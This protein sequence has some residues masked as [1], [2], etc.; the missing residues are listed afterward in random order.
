[1]WLNKNVSSYLE[2]SFLILN[3]SYYICLGCLFACSE[4]K[5]IAH[6][7]QSYMNNQ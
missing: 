7:F 4:V 6:D 5:S 3:V 2:R 1:M